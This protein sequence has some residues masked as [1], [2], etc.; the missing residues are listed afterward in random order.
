MGFWEMLQQKPEM[1]LI[2]FGCLGLFVLLYTKRMPSVEHMKEFAT[3]LNSKGGNIFVLMVM[4]LWFFIL[5]MRFF[6]Y[7]LGLIVQGK[8]TPDNAVLLMGVT[9]ITGSAFGGFSGALLKTM[10]GEAMPP[11]ANTNTSSSVTATTLNTTNP[12]VEKEV[13]KEGDTNVPI[14]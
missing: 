4:S 14:T 1:L 3:I 8:L 2:A 10:T 13:V 12:V 11:S 9:F 6:Y 7:S 5:G